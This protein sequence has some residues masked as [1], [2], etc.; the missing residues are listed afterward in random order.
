MQ[1]Y[2][3][4][5]GPPGD[6]DFSRGSWREQRSTPLP[7]PADPTRMGPSGQPAR[8]ANQGEAAAILDTGLPLLVHAGGVHFQPERSSRP[9]LRFDLVLPALPEDVIKQV[10]AILH[11]VRQHRRPLQGP[12]GAVSGALHPQAAGSLPEDHLTAVSSATGGPASSWRPCWPCCHPGSLMASS[13]R[14]SSSTGCQRTSATTWWQPASTPPP[15][16]DNFWFTANSTKGGK[17]R[18]Q[19]VA[20]VQEDDQDLEEAVAV[21][22]VQPKRPQPKKKAAKGGKGKGTMCYPHRKYGADCLE[23]HRAHHLHL[24]GKLGCPAAATA[25]AAPMGTP[26]CL[27]YLVDPASSRRYLVDSGSAFSIIPHKSAATPTGPRLIHRR[28]HTAYVLGPRHVQPCTLGCI[29]FFFFCEFQKDEYR[30]CLPR[31]LEK[32]KKHFLFFCTTP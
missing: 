26:S 8:S 1:G 4:L 2:D 15:G 13:S 31:V 18:S 23:V 6:D 16:R 25:A 28:R 17:K 5:D 14:P 7:L 10:R 32:D 12:Q 29:N 30:V 19:A 24:D 3:N 22:S 20:A 11:T 9:R 27:L 21:L